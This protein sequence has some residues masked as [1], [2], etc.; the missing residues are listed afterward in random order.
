MSRKEEG[1]VPQNRTKFGSEG[2]DG[3]DHS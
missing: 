2:S 1:T 3:A